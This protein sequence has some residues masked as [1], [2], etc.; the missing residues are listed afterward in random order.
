MA[1]PF[2]ITPAN[3]L[4]ALMSGVQGY[5]RGAASVKDAEIKAGRQEAMA[6]LQNGADPQNAL[7]RLIGVGDIQGATVL[8]KLHESQSQQNGIYGHPLYTQNA[9]G[10]VSLNA[11]GKK[12]TLVPLAAPPGSRHMLPQ[13]HLNLG[14]Q[15]LPQP[16]RGAVGPP[17][18]GGQPSPARG[19]PPRGQPA[20]DVNSEGIPRSQADRVNGPQPA[21]AAPAAPLTR[22]VQ[23]QSFPRPAGIPIN[24]QGR[25]AA[26]ELGKAQG[27]AQA[28]YPAIANSTQ[29]S[30]RLIEE[31]I[32]HPGRETAT[33]L[34]SRID[35]RNY[36]AGTNAADFDS[37]GKQLEGRV[38]LDAFEQLR[39]GGA[40][41]EAEGN[42]ATAAHARLQRSQS[43]EQYLGA[44]KELRGILQKGLKV[45]RL[46]AAGRFDQ[47]DSEL[48]LGVPD[49]TVTTPGIDDLVQ[50]YRTK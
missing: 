25:E 30:L 10:S 13:T 45:A 4:Q 33:G 36:I 39:G 21:P 38:F 19:L 37:R 5:D 22:P 49:V 9:D 2:E 42:K 28:N 44:L 50:Q 24:V 11:L 34:S 8:A 16:T 14:D 48:G 40:I 32:S 3:P 27:K 41:T 1:N 23:T 26:E 31:A 43:D 17:P 35:P 18:V 46:R 15:F 29:T 12:G 47:A 6:A 20:L 7:S